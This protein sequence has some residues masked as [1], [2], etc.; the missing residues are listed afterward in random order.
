ML[1]SPCA[2]LAPLLKKLEMWAPLGEPEQRAVLAL[3]HT[4]R[5]LDPGQTIVWEGERPA[6]ACALLWGYAFRQKVAGNGARQILSIHMPGDMVDLHNA[7]LGAADHGVQALTRVE[8]AFIPVDAVRALAFAMPSVGM[9]LWHETLVDGSIFREW[10]L[11]VGRRDARA[12]IAHLL[13]EFAV[14]LEAAG[15]GERSR[16]ELPMTQEQLADATG[17]TSVHVN[18]TLKGLERDGLIERTIR[19]IST[20]NWHDL[21]RAGD[22]QPGYLHLAHTSRPQLTRGFDGG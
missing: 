1:D 14:R 3:P 11:N 4:V 19:A 6:H 13:C 20:A 10:M 2:A 18:R 17:L 22:F 5:R 15:L 16:Y 21:A 7:L 12:R 8:A 9:A